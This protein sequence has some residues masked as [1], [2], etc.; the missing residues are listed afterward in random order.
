VVHAHDAQSSWPCLTRPSTS[1]ETHCFSKVAEAWIRGSSPRMTALFHVTYS[2]TCTTAQTVASS[3]MRIYALFITLFLAVSTTPANA[4][5]GADQGEKLPS[6]H[7]LMV[8]REGGAVC[9]G[10]VIHPRVVFT[11]AHCVGAAPAS[12]RIH[13]RSMDG[14]HELITPLR[15]VRHPAYKV[16]AIKT[17]SKSIDLALIHLKDALPD[18]F[19]PMALR[20]AVPK[21]GDPLIV[22]GF[23]LSI[24]ASPESMGTLRTASLQTITPY[25]PSAIVLWAKGASSE[26]GAC[27]GDSG[28]ALLFKGALVAITS[29]S[30]GFEK[31]RCGNLTQGILLGA[32]KHWINTVLQEWHTSIHWITD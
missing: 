12:V 22:T 29:W 10:V 27:Q 23:G 8:L 13:F 31:K 3:G 28:G 1:L 9:S 16:D 19:S 26:A 30:T 11:A 32:Q 15:V 21:T 14:R 18:P 25:G 20:Q 2:Q 5:V 6:T 24:E 4:I 7:M 17:R